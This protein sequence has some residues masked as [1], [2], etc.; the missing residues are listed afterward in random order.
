MVE[1]SESQFYKHGWNDALSKMKGILKK[2][3]VNKQTEE[4]ILFALSKEV[5]K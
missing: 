4:L 3:K 1:I 2:L 5:M